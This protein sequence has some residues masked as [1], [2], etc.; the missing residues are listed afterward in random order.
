MAYDTRR[1]LGRMTE[2]ALTP[3]QKIAARLRADITAGHLP[4]GH[5]LPA[6]RDLAEQHNVSRTT[7]GKALA[8]LKADGLVV[9]RHGSGAYVR[10]LHPIRRL[11]PDRYARHL[12]QVT[13]VQAYADSPST[14]DTVQRQGHQ[15][16]DVALVPASQ[17]VAAVLGV[18][19][20]ADVYERARVV[21][22]AGVPTHTMTSYYRRADVE[23][24][25]LVDPSPGIAGPRGGFAVLTG[26]GLVPHE[27]TEDISARM[28][29]AD[30]MLV[31]EIDGE[32][33]V[34]LHR[35]T[36]TAGGRVIEYARGIH[37]ASRF[38]WS[39][40]FEIPD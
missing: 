19:V 8:L 29:T 20:G 40:T 28:P 5:R 12:W 4:P 10:E 33:V 7:A 14:S 32:P 35:V 9:T 24:T 11:G 31:L 6:V 36:R 18:E 3:S 37:T 22:R 2:P 27:I 15:T 26:R 17:R 21:T 13:T 25:P 34:E 39:Y 16:Q 30:E 23:G 38:V 1:K